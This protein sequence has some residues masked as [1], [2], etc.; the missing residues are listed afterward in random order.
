MNYHA[1]STTFRTFRSLFNETHKEINNNLVIWQVF[2]WLFGKFSFGYLAIAE[3]PPDFAPF[4]THKIQNSQD[5]QFQLHFFKKTA[6]QDAT[7]TDA[8]GMP[9]TCPLALPGPLS[10]YQTF[11]T[12]MVA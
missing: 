7:G 5:F 12:C 9:L 8:T 2:V 6:N 11:G 4:M 1:K 3:A 10:A